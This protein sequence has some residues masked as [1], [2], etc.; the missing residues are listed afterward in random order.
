MAEELTFGVVFVAGLLSFLSPCFLP[1]IPAYISR[2]S[3]TAK[4]GRLKPF[5]NSVFF[6][7]GFSVIFVLLGSAAGLFGSRLD[8]M[9]LARVGGAFIIAFGLHTM[10]LLEVGL[11]QREYR[12]FL[13]ASKGGYL[14][15]TVMGASFGVGW[16]PC[17]GAILASVLVLAG[18]QESAYFGASL[19]GI[20]SLGLGVPFMLAGLFAGKIIPII[21]RLNQHSNA[22]DKISGVLLIGLGIAV[23]TNNFARI[24]SIFI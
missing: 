19:L 10:G 18:T 11:L 15:S 12:P 22:I 14:G 17:V 21:R 6:V 8:Q 23:F 7:A 3:G 1:L 16:S 2:I 24:I 9:L 4:G 20:Y 13:K 5:V